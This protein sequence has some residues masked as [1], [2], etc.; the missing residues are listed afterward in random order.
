MSAKA[1][2]STFLGGDGMGCL[3]PRIKFRG[4]LRVARSLFCDLATDLALELH[5]CLGSF[6][7]SSHIPKW[8]AT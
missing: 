4:H 3:E 6:P 7:S 8:E 5:T 1:R 2:F